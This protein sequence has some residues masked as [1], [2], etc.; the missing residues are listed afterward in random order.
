MIICFH[1]AALFYASGSERPPLWSARAGIRGSGHGGST[2][3]GERQRG[4]RTGEG[5]FPHPVK[6]EEAIW[7]KLMRIL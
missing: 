1:A 3:K 4:D 7:Q 6:G 2:A 5:I